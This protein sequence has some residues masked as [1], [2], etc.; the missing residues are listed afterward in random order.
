MLAMTPLGVAVA[1]VLGSALIGDPRAV[2]APGG[3][4]MAWRLAV[5]WVVAV[6]LP[7]TG[8]G[9]A[10]RAVRR[11]DSTARAALVANGL[12]VT[13][14]TITTLFGETINPS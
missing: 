14:L 8:V 5:T 3:M 2:N 6:A 12:L 4:A 1:F 9:F 13:L 11:D 10:R 7:A